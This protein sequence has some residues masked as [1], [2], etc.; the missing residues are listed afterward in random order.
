MY[1]TYQTTI[2]WTKRVN[3]HKINQPF[4]H[5]TNCP[6]WEANGRSDSPVP[7]CPYRTAALCIVD[8]KCL[9][10]GRNL[11]TP[12]SR[13]L[14][15]LTGLQPVKKFPALYGTPKVHYR[16]HKC[17]LPVPILS[18]FDPVHNP[19]PPSWISILILSS[20]LR[21]ARQELNIQIQIGKLWVIRVN[22][23]RNR[24]K[25]IQVRT[26]EILW[27]YPIFGHGINVKFATACVPIR[28]SVML[29][30]L[31]LPLRIFPDR[32]LRCGL[33]FVWITWVSHYLIKMFQLQT[34][35]A[36]HHWLLQNCELTNMET[37]EHWD[38]DVNVSFHC[39]RSL[40]GTH[41]GGVMKP[42][43]HTAKCGHIQWHESEQRGGC[44]EVT[45]YGKSPWEI[46]VECRLLQPQGSS[47]SNELRLYPASK[48]G[49]N[50]NDEGRGSTRDFIFETQWTTSGSKWHCLSL[51]TTGKE[52]LFSLVSSLG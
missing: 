15:N 1:M 47:S 21:L 5:V 10:R 17:P 51:Q 49:D 52:T 38:M 12:W 41:Q 36:D 48:P 13:V 7:S 35:D 6:P 31:S 18:Q 4:N 24:E 28:V 2:H 14:E 20:H 45:S 16:I 3:N 32:P 8:T 22:Y 42:V 37:K 50:G 19:H 43:I 29:W 23:R 26:T 39:S 46:W 30:I 11:L 33:R 44:G 25:Y 9:L 40:H 34:L 27:M